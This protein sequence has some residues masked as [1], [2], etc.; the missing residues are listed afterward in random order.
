MDKQKKSIQSELKSINDQI[1]NTESSIQSLTLD[2]MNK[3]PKQESE[4]SHRLSQKEI[5]NSPDNYLK[6][7]RVIFS[8]GQK[9]NENFRKDYEYDKEYVNFIAEHKEMHGELIEIWT[10]PYGGIAAE[11][12]EV[13][14][15]IPVWGPRYLAEQIRRKSYHRLVMK[16][17]VITESNSMGQM[18]GAISAASTIPRLEA[19]PVNQR[20][21]VFSSAGNF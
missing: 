7:K 4:P 2:E 12:W 16:Q 14:T 11:F 17:N 10:R 21:S 13:P 15:G 5:S 8:Q 3:A 19:H 9:F 6:P 1:K 18:Y 20:R